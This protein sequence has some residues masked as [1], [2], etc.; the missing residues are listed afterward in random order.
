MSMNPN[1]NKYLRHFGTIRAIC[2]HLVKEANDDKVRFDNFI[3]CNEIII[4]TIVR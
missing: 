1:D 2:T 4:L 3:L